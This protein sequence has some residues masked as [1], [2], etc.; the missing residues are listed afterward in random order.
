MCQR[1]PESPAFHTAFVH[2][3][4][5]FKSPN[6]ICF[7]FESLINQALSLQ[8][9]ATVKSLLAA[10]V[11]VSSRAWG[12]SSLQGTTKAILSFS[13]RAPSVIP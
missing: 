1:P 2:S 11:P 9:N 10:A 3:I 13:S 6:E 4:K 8:T 5:L 12:A 7:K